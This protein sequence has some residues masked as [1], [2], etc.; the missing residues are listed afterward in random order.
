MNAKT[1]VY[2]VIGD[3]ISHSLS[4]NIHNAAFKRLKLNSVY[5]AFKVQKEF[6]VE[7]VKGLKSI[8]V[9][10][11]NVTIP[12]KVSI[13]PLLDK[14]DPLAEKIGAVNTVK[15]V[16]G[17]LIGYNTDGEGVL[18]A[19]EVEDVSLKNKKVVMVGAGG[20]ARAL[21]FTFANHAKEIVILNRTE[22]KAL[23]LASSISRSYN[24]PVKGLK[25]NMENLSL[26]LK[27]AEVVVNA[28]SVGMHP[29][30]DETPIPKNLIKPEMVV[31]DVVY[32]PIKT[33]LLKEAKQ[34]GAKTINGLAML[35]FQAVKAFEIW[36]GL[37]PPIDAMFRAALR[38]LK[39]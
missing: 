17:K 25:L 30:I 18:K 14:L 6:L 7:A 22:E 26:E 24:L 15:N 3:P 1:S 19:F 21:A 23:E 13:I 9:K 34:V 32:R 11:F 28:T 2:C 16:D 5:L 10:G 8:G 37:T 4:P 33:R 35:V 12:H 29:N 20:A 31:F 27:D 39:G 36:T 38:G